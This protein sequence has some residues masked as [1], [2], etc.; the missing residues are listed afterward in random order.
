MKKGTRYRRYAEKSAFLMEKS[1]I[2]A[3]LLKTFLELQ[4]FKRPPASVGL[5]SPVGLSAPVD[6]I[7]GSRAQGYGS[8]GISNMS[9]N[10]HKMMIIINQPC[11]FGMALYSMNSWFRWIPDE[12]HIINLLLD[13]YVY[14]YIYLFLGNRS[15]LVGG[16]SGATLWCL[17]YTRGIDAKVARSCL[18]ICT[19]ICIYLIYI[20]IYIYPYL[21]LYVICLYRYAWC[22]WCLCQESW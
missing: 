7:A 18:G 6:S 1:T 10:W 16:W 12:A 9:E 2:D 17:W 21:Y 20:Y 22:L 19:C 15:E 4:T 14:I 11:S 8:L 5:L 3:N 13:M